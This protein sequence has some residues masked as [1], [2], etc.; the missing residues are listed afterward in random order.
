MSA[1]DST[2]AST[3]VDL[4]ALPPPRRPFRRLTFVVMGVTALFA[5]R[6]ALGLRGELVYT[7]RGGAPTDLGELGPRAPTA[8]TPNS[9][10]RAEG[11]LSDRDVVRYSRPL[12]S[13]SYR[14]SALADNPKVWVELRVPRDTD[15]TH[16]VAPGS[17]VGRLVPARGAGLR[18]RALETA[19]EAS[20]HGLPRDAWLL[21]DG[22]SPSGTRWVLA[23]EAMLIAF[24][25]FNVAG[26]FRLAK[27]VR[28]A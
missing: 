21:I 5:L 19:A 16:F 8:L 15:E 24:A 10:V 3:D 27:P 26:I 14:L 6:L 23:L 12:E 25:A 22:E 13:D 18:Y 1:S 20:G 28:D 7:L 4:A 17:F 2:R 9:W 11:A